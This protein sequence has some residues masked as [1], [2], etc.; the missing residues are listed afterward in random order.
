MLQHTWQFACG[1]NWPL[2][3][4]IAVVLVV[5]RGKDIVAA[6]KSRF[7]RLPSVLDNKAPETPTS[8]VHQFEYLVEQ[9]RSDRARLQREIDAIDSVLGDVPE[10]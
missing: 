8:A 6:F 10:R 7:Q 2:I 3:G 5:W 4:V 9:L 1:L